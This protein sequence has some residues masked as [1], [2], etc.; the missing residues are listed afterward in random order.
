MIFH[1]IMNSCIYRSIKIKRSVGEINLYIILSI[2]LIL[3]D[4]NYIQLYK[5]KKNQ[6]IMLA[7]TNTYF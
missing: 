4:A 6:L 7:W 5:Y 1:I 3:Q 2:V